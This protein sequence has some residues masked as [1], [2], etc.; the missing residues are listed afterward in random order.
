MANILLVQFESLLGRRMSAA[1]KTD[2]H[3]VRLVPKGPESKFAALDHIYD[4]VIV[5]CCRASSFD[6][7]RFCKDR[8][9]SGQRSTIL[10]VVDSFDKQ[11]QRALIHAGANEFILRSEALPELVR[12][13]NFILR[14][15]AG[16]SARV[17]SQT[18]HRTPSFPQ[19]NDDEAFPLRSEFTTNLLMHR[20]RG[21]FFVNALTFQREEHENRPIKKVET[22]SITLAAAKVSSSNART[23]G[24]VLTTAINEYVIRYA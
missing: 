7:E 11:E 22:K 8:K 14:P 19:R 2:G 3:M 15:P 20:F 9:Q 24:T 23:D 13:V 4:L 1:L 12:R 16:H 18:M 17:N 6:P 5:E 10:A 21:T